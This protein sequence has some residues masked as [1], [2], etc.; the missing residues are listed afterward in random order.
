MSRQRISRAQR[1]RVAATAGNRCAY[2]HTTERIIGPFLEIDHIIPEAAGGTT[3]DHNLTLACPL[4]NSH[5]SALI[6]ALDPETGNLAPLF[7]PNEQ[8]WRE[9]FGWLESGAIITGKTPIGRATV[10]ALDMNHP[11]AVATRRLWITVGWHPPAED[12]IGTL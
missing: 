3:I 12:E 7:H 4:C 2:C 10:A 1:R 11:D 9:H 5:K 8:I 6:H